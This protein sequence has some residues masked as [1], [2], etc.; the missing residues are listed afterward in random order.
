VRESEWLRVRRVTPDLLEQT[1]RFLEPGFELKASGFEER[2]NTLSAQEQLDLC[3]AY[4]AKPTLSADDE[5]ILKFIMAHGNDLVWSS[6]VSVLTRL[7]SRYLVSEFV[8]SRIEKQREPLANFYHAAEILA[9]H[10]LIPLLR[11]KYREYQDMGI[12]PASE[13]QVLSFDY[14]TCCRTLWKLTGEQR[15][16]QQ[17]RMFSQARSKSLKDYSKHLLD[18]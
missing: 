8:K 10:S 3:T 9:D 1:S 13:D 18:H 17:I 15:Y 12:T 5:T 4:H 2:W 14:L 7:P 11:R 6:V 16:E